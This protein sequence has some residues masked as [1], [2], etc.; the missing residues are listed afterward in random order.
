MAG[1]RLTS[2]GRGRGPL[3][4]I[5]VFVAC[6]GLWNAANYPTGA[7]YDAGSHMQYADGLI[8][9]WKL[10][11]GTGEYYTPP[12]FYLLAGSADWIAKQLGSGDPDRAAQV[13]N[14][15]YW[16]GTILLVAAVARELW[17][18]R[19]RIE[20]GAAAF[21]ALLP[22][23]VETEAMFHPDPLSLLLSTLALWLCVR[24]FSNPRYMVALGVTLGAAQLVRA[25]AL[26][27]VAA[28]F[29]GLLAG[30][31][32]RELAVVVALAIVIPAPW[33]IHQRVTYGGQPEFS[34]PAQ[35]TPLPH[36]FYVGLGIPGVITKPY[37]SHHLQWIP[38]AYDG[39]F[40]DYFGAWIWHSGTPVGK[41]ASVT[42]PTAG[43]RHRLVLQGLLG[44]FPTLVA[45]AGWVLMARAALRRP[46]A[47]AV[48]LLPAIAILGYIY[49]AATYWTSDGDLLKTSYM[50][51][52]A[53]AWA[54]AFG[55]ALDRL[56][57][58]AW[59][60]VLALLAVCA[61]VG[62]PF[63]VY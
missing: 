45:L 38:V 16:L 8:P 37:R 42:T 18:G 34:Q 26:W 61:V 14:I 43:Q 53:G 49:F 36:R 50:L 2:F 55:F 56:R 19:R 25:F 57:G 10:P 54:L 29:L 24:T 23:V 41:T 46:Q 63:L 52:A 32:W 30:R 1:S 39:L 4:A 59:P 47:L 9:G 51:S 62:L 12:G 20:L 58:R 13:L 15:A 3:V 21:V 48:A 27:T 11:Q 33:Y 5:C 60:V 35:P 6:L 7:G 31:R 44:I 22:V 28:V 40:G 17:P